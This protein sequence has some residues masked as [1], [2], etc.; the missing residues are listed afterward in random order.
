MSSTSSDCRP[1]FVDCVLCGKTFTARGINIHLARSHH[2]SQDSTHNV[3]DDVNINSNND[4]DGTHLNLDDGTT[5]NNKEEKCPVCGKS[6]KSISIHIS[7]AHAQEYRSNLVTKYAI[8]NSI[9]VPSSAVHTDVQNNDVATNPSHTD[10]TEKSDSIKSFEKRFEEIICTANWELFETTTLEF[11]EYLSEASKTLPGP[12]H[13][14]VKYYCIMLVKKD[15]QILVFRLNHL[16]IQN[17]KIKEGERRIERNTNMILRN[18]II[19]ISGG[20]WFEI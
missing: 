7:K 11:V 3:E 16:I 14:A 6:Y 20:K 8:E 18:T 10:K 4:N 12:K 19:I 2:S 17:D 15:R 13:P 5:K 9:I 1:H